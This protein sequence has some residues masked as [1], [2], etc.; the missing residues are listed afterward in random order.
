MSKGASK[1]CIVCDKEW[2]VS[3]DYN[4]CK[5]KTK[6]DNGAGVSVV[7]RAAAQG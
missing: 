5:V 7:R 2:H 6:S 3:N 4:S 1:A